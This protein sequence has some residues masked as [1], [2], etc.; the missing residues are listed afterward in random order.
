MDMFMMKGRRRILILLA[1]GILAAAVLITSGFFHSRKDS[2]GASKSCRI[3]SREEM[4]EMIERSGKAFFSAK[5]FAWLGGAPACGEE[6]T[7]VYLPCSLSFFKETSDV[8]L[9]RQSEWEKLLS[10]L[11]C[12]QEGCA[13][14]VAEDEKMADPA[15]AVREGYQFA[16]LLM[17][18][19]GAVPFHIVLTGLP[20]LCI[21]KTDS[22]EIKGKEKHSGSIRMIDCLSQNP[23]RTNGE[24]LHCLFHVRGNVSSTLSKKPYKIALTDMAGDKKKVSWLGLR[25]DDDW[26]LNPLYT[27]ETR[28]R[29]MT[30]YALW[31]ETQAFSRHPQASSR[32]RYVELF[33]DNS[34]LGLYGLMEPVDRKQLGLSEG[35]LLYKIDRWDW[36]YPYS[37]LYGEKEQAQET[38]IKNNKGFTCVEIR[39]PL[40]WDKTAT[41]KPMEAF[42]LFTYASQDET[43][44]E[45][46]GLSTDMDSI[47]S[48]SLFCGML[49]A[50]DNNWKN[51]FLIAKKEQGGYRLFRTVWDLNYVLGDIF[52]FKPDQG[53][54]AFDPA[55]ASLWIPEEDTT[56]DY[57]AFLSADPS[58]KE[59]LSE[60]WSQ[61]RK[62]GISADRVIDLAEKNRLLLEE[63]GSILREQR[64]WETVGQGKSGGSGRDAME[65]MEKWIRER[66]DYLDDLFGFSA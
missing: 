32:M 64:R 35:D 38:E 54:T 58:L 29:E 9:S 26:I 21:E 46:A 25:E 41:W 34:Y 13:I 49:H 1:A 50:M 45:K 51:S 18:K 17:K 4:D 62:G 44:L 40:S 47:V 22:T 37:E 15:A 52:V 6:E 7:T 43:E 27:D 36:E 14:Y 53:Y 5:D 19:E 56:Y 23:E 63:T 10:N 8:T 57:E 24:S 28:V 12:P 30:A 33:M 42:H 48:L 16:A 31:E 61:W 59:V 20:A 11:M 55:S 66:F 3:L 2:G 60:K 65:R 39:W